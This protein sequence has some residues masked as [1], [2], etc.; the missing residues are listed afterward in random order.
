[1]D[2]PHV[3]QF[4]RAYQALAEH[5]DLG[6]FREMLD[7]GIESWAWDGE[8]NCRGRDEVM[9]VIEG[10]LEA[11]VPLRMSHFLGSGDVFVM[12]PDLDGLPPFFPADA[13]GLFQVVEM[14]D[15]KI[16]RMR[17]F[18]RRQEALV[19]AGIAASP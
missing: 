1:M 5:G 8:G 11:G 9:Q 18:V 4:R 15:G 14:R 3:E 6:V 19:A 10:A 7:P 16:V 2:G 17:D 12:V 13:E